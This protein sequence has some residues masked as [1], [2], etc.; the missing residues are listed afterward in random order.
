MQL[1]T[2]PVL[3]PSGHGLW[4][5]TLVP[6]LCIMSVLL[7]ACSQGPKPPEVAGEAQSTKGT[8]VAVSPTIVLNAL[9]IRTIKIQAEPIDQGTIPVR[10]TLTG[11]V[12]AIARAPRHPY[13]RSLFAAMPGQ[14]WERDIENPERAVA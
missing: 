5:R 8:T 3:K 2:F 10:L 1:Q 7:T 11:T 14:A 4:C 12:Q 9:Q 13:T 6:G